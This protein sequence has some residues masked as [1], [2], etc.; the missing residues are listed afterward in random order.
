MTFSPHVR[1]RA[2][3]YHEN[4]ARLFAHLGGT[5]ADDAVLLLMFHV[6]HQKKPSFIFQCPPQ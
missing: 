3:R 2:V 6:K 4:A 5:V 1:T